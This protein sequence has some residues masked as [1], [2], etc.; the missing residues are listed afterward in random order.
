MCEHI[1]AEIAKALM[2]EHAQPDPGF[3]GLLARVF[4]LCE[5]DKNAPSKWCEKKITNLYSLQELISSHSWHAV[6][7]DDEAHLII[8]TKYHITYSRFFISHFDD[9]DDMEQRMK[10]F[11]Q[12]ILVCFFFFYYIDLHG[13]LS[14]FFNS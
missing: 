7:C 14:A 10:E 6:I 4:T 13:C 11:K 9:Q 1:Q 5:P 2:C 3:S 8:M 12:E